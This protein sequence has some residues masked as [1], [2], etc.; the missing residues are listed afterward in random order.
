MGYA[1]TMTP[2]ITMIGQYFNKRKALAMSVA[3]AG[4]SLG[5]FVLP[6]LVQV[7]SLVP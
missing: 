7:S 6:P 4:T 5:G 2:G 3:S 1:L